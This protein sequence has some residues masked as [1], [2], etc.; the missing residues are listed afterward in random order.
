MSAKTTNELESKVNSYLRNLDNWLKA[1]KLHLNID[2]TCYS[3]FSPNKIPVPT[4]TIKVN[5][6]EIKCVKQC[7]YLGVIIDDELKWTSHIEFF[8][9]KLKGLLGILYKVR[10]KLPDWC[11]QNIILHL[12]IHIYC[13]V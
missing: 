12:C 13:M 5:D 4:V 7:N 6:T 1:N 10:Y 2:K 8:P 11:L 9:Q 3:A